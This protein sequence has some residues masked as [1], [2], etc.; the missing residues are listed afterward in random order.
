MS[1]NYTK[2]FKIEAVKKVLMREKGSSISE[3]ARSLNVNPR[4][5]L[6]WTKAMPREA[7][8]EAPSRGGPDQKS[9]CNWTLQE[10]FEAIVAAATLTGEDLN[11]FCRKKGLFP[12]H[13][14]KWKKA[15]FEMQNKQGRD[16]SGENRILKNEIKKL[17]ADL[18]RKDKAL[19]EAASLLILKKKAQEIWGNDEED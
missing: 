19:A 10:K 15:F 14:E 3:V 9:P 5:L 18:R 11:E 1:T 4:T 2:T 16:Q 12:H 13:L 7:N 8:E 6:N 17:K